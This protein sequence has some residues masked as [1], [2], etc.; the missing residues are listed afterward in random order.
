MQK[1]STSYFDYLLHNFHDGEVFRNGD[2]GL[3]ES[4]S[5]HFVQDLESVSLQNVYLSIK[6]S[7]RG[8]RNQILTRLLRS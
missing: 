3:G 8:L 4:I 5:Q 2:W 1:G 6:F 7:E